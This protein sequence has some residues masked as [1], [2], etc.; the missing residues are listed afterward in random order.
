MDLV[1]ANYHRQEG[2]VSKLPCY[3]KREDTTRARAM[4][5]ENIDPFRKENKFNHQNYMKYL[6]CYAGCKLVN[7]PLMLMWRPESRVFCTNIKKQ[8]VF[9][10]Q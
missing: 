8:M 7:V 3:S 10:S 6:I 9:V 5:Y 2:H 1:I 4:P